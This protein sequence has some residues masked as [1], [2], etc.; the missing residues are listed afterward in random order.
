MRIGVVSDIHG[1][2]A[3]LQRALELMAPVDELLCLGD[4]ISEYRFS[5]ETV[6]LLRGH[7][8]L[9]IR[10]N[11]E[12]VFF[13]PLG[14]PAR[15]PKWIDPA[16]RDWLGALP[17]ERWLT[18]G[19]RRLH[20]VH[21]TPWAPGGEYVTEHD[22]RFA[23]F[24]DFG[25]DIVLYGHTHLPVVSRVRDTLVVNPGS[26]GESR[27]HDGGPGLSCAVLEPERLEA[28]ILRFEV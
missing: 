2:V 19:G 4:S 27:L 13:G 22:P 3:A 18:R 6:A 5:N 24:A 8:A 9:A 1:Q 20:V 10:G 21:S 25:A 14:A 11:H 17:S 26:V 28:T 12:D 16:L 7:A 23:R 15:S